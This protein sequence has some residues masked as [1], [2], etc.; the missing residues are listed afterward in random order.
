MYHNIK[1]SVRKIGL[2]LDEAGITIKDQRTGK[3]VSWKI[4]YPTKEYILRL[5]NFLIEE[6]RLDEDPISE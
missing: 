4:Y 6:F 5:H 3:T 1:R 2:E